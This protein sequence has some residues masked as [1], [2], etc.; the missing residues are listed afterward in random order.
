M[1]KGLVIFQF[2]ASMVLIVGTYIV[3]RQLHYMT[4]QPLGVN[5]DQIL[6][7][8]SPVKTED[9]YQKAEAFKNEIKSLPGVL[10]VTGS[11]AVP[12]KEVGKFL[13]NRRL[14]E[15][16]EADRLYEMLPVD[17][18][19]V[20][21]YGLQMVAGRNFDRSRP[22]DQY[23][24]ILN[25]TALRQFG[26]RSAS[27]AIGQKVLLEANPGR[28][29]EII[30]VIGDYHH[31]SL[32]QPYKPTILF[33]DPDF[34]WIPTAYYSIKIHAGNI[35]DLTDKL[36]GIWHRFFPESSLDYFFLDQFFN[37]QYSQDRRFGRTFLI[38]SSLAIWIACLGLLGLTF[39]TT[40]RRTKEICIR[41]V[42]GATVTG[43][44]FMLAWDTLKLV[45]IGGM[46]AIPVSW[47]VMSKWL[48]GYAFRIPLQAV[49]WLLP[50]GIMV[51]IA[52]LTIGYLTIRAAFTNPATTLRSE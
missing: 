28:S 4:S 18:D 2:T 26:F 12:G 38:F 14:H 44:I 36:T 7:L 51:L 34:R 17:Y 39:Y 49:H 8:E 32:E 40:A 16:P 1:R 41:K 37:Q 47:Y 33:M 24:L 52:C 23:G 27:E 29:N 9:Y 46:V 15:S 5:T 21:T 22:T 10:A 30:G 25:Q 3:Y 13:A 6:V 11:G 19:F 31:Q 48:E 45:L 42:V 50:L 43:I 35:P 20:T